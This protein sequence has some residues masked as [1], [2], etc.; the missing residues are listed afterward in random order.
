MARTGAVLAGGASRRMGQ[1]KPEIVVDDI[2]LLDRA[3]AVLQAVADDVLIVGSQDD[4][5][6]ST[7]ALSADAPIHVQDR[8]AGLGPLAGI[9]TALAASRHPITII[10]AVDHPWVTPAVLRLLAET[11]ESAPDHQAAM[12]ATDRGPQP[13]VA[14]YR[15]TALSTITRLLD[16]GERRA[17]AVVDALNMT[18]IDPEVW[19]RADPRGWSV[20]DL[21][22]PTDVA[23]SVRSRSMAVTTFDHDT[24]EDRHETVVVEEPLEIRAHGPGQPAHTVMT[25]LRTPGHD[26]DLAVGWMISEG[27][28]T[29][30]DLSGW[31]TGDALALARPDDQVTLRLTR[32]LDTSLVAHRHATATASCGVCGRATI[33]E[34]VDRSLP[35]VDGFTHPIPS[36][37]LA[38]LPDRLRTAQQV[39]AATGGLHATG[40]FDEDGTLVTLR[41]DVGRHNAL[42]AAIGARARLG[43]LPLRATIAVLSGRIGFELVAKAAMAGIPV[44]AAV[45]APTDLAIR[46]AQRCGITLVGFLRGG[47]GHLYAHPERIA[48]GAP[49]GP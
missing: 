44:V 48:V 41:E 42:D 49:S 31:D 3:V 27:L 25:T 15:Q 19:R 14:A 40:L 21:D 1:P 26:V 34:L 13:L 45:G 10:I 16:D 6:S 5:P 30:H 8:R 22:T 46:S 12:L 33:D 23:A 37:L 47:R 20:R 18:A 9:E 35:V 24:S 28:M 43:E 2:R 4:A 36:Q 29:Q 32:P 11:L 39:F 17:M 38:R 7:A